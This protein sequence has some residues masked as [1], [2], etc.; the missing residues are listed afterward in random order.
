MFLPILIRL[1][2]ELHHKK[3]INDF[4][5]DPDQPGSDEKTD[6]NFPVFDRVYN[7]GGGDAIASLVNFTP[8][9][10]YIWTTIENGIYQAFLI[11]R[12]KNL[13]YIP[14]HACSCCLP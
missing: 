1:Q 12:R 4:H 2:S 10:F 3:D 9:I 7:E 6:S 13:L 8:A 14:N 5:A 11:G